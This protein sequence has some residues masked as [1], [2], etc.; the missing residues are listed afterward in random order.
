VSRADSAIGQ[1][2]LRAI[3][4]SEP[5]HDVASC[6][7]STAV[8]AADDDGFAVT[9]Q[10]PPLIV[11]SVSQPMIVGGWAKYSIQGSS[12]AKY[13][14]LGQYFRTNACLLDT[15]GNVTTNQAG[16]LSPYGEYFPLQAGAAA[17][18]TTPDI[19]TGAQGTGVVRVV[20][21]NTDANRD[22]T[23]DLSYFGP[24]Q[25]SPSRPFRFWVNDN[26]DSGDD[27]GDGV[28]G[29]GA[30]ADGVRLTPISV[31]TYYGGF[32]SGSTPQ[33][34]Y[35]VQ[36][37]RDLVDFFPVYLNIGSLF[38]SNALSAGISATDTN[39]Q[40]IL[41][42][43][44]GALRFAYTDLT[45]TNYMDFLR[46]M[47]ESSNLANALLT[48]VSNSGVALSPSFVADIAENNQGIILVEAWESTTQPLVLSIYHGTNLIGQTSLYLSIS[49]VEQMFRHKNLMLNQT[50]TDLHG[51][52]DR[53]TDASV[54]NEPD[55]NDKN[56]VFLHG[57]NVNPNQAR[58]W[59]A[60]FYKRMYWSGSHAKFY[61]VTWKA[62]DS[63]GLIPG[64]PDVTINLQTNIVNAFLT[65]PNLAAFLVT[66]TNETVVAAHSLGNMTVLSALNDCTN[67]NFNIS[68]YFMID[69]AVPMEAI[70][71]YQGQTAPMLAGMIHS[72]WMP[73]A[74]RLYASEWFGLFPA[75][76][77]RN[78]LTWSN[79]LSNFQNADVYNFYSSGEEV[80][81]AT[82]SDPPTDLLSSFTNDSRQLSN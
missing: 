6:G 2:L 5:E 28:P 41:S 31:L 39:Y 34:V 77:G 58:G 44:D 72:E 60:D 37:R 79:R 78:A 46:D 75:G 65:A 56:F 23:L 40:F 69:A 61:G 36:G 71:G 33:F 51:P 14:Y 49:G 1:L 74:N 52:P 80:L 38:Q 21:L 50:A 29:Q 15:N 63:Q 11:G 70:E 47:N 42:Q 81:R 53:L 27:G 22:G 59:F 82:T 9:N 48:T 16:I 66:L 17:L 30:V 64:L 26:D 25:T 54:P 62:S 24:D 20:S 8:P 4:Q 45:P 12:P 55:T 73:Y 32:G 10:T 7:E 18:V 19:D 35:Q 13:A 76:D 3:D 67:V 68:K 57:Y 43:A